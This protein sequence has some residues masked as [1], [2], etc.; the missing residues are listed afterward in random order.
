MREPISGL[1][2]LIGAILSAVGLVQLIY[3]AVKYGSVWHVVSFSIFG[4][5]L[6][7][8]YTASSLYHLLPVSER[9]IKILRRIDHMMIFVL[10]AGTYTP[11]CLVPLRG[12]WGWSLLSSVWAIALGG[13][14]MKAVWIDAPRWLS[15]A[16]Y[17]I[18]G[19]IVVVA[20]FPL[21]KTV[22][23]GGMVWMV[24]GGVLYTIGALIYGL[25]WP[26]IPSKIFGFHEIFHLFVMGGSVS[27]YWLMLKYV[28]PL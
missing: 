8:L 1:T 17:G 13:I 26:R 12:A 15:T 23:M 4:T 19:W 14:I 5:S 7:L 9:V 10:I 11:V 25:K 18:M 6:V 3:L 22:P 24:I 20:F 21:I 16:I 28:L 27:H 2:H